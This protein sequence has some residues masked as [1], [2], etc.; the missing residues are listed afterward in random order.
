MRGELIVDSFVICRP[1]INFR[2][3][4]T[5]VI[6]IFHVLV[7]DFFCINGSR[8]VSINNQRRARNRL[9]CFPSF[10]LTHRVDFMFSFIAMED[11]QNKDSM[12]LT[13]FLWSFLTQ[14]VNASVFLVECQAFDSRYS[15]I[16]FRVENSFDCPGAQAFHYGCHTLYDCMLYNGKETL[17]ENCG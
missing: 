5:F 14:S 8:K 2:L 16:S 3:S 12:L 9:R 11:N 1:S 17:I 10:I 6:E 13:N 4:I 15:R 7:L